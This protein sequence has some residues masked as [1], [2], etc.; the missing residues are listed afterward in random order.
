LGRTV[1]GAWRPNP[2]AQLLYGASPQSWLPGAKI[3]FVRYKGADPDTP[4]ATR[5][6]VT[7]TLPD[8][9]DSVWARAGLRV[10]V[11]DYDPQ[12]TLSAI[13]LGEPQLVE[14][15]ALERPGATVK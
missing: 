5:K 9:L 15:W 12:C 7:G 6:T 2:A 10:L 14:T 8:Q 13:L 11:L 3:E 1:A 4:V